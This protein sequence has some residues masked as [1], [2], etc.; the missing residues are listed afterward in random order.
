[1]LECH[2]TE[3]ELFMTACYNGEIALW[4]ARDGCILNSFNRCGGWKGRGS[5]GAAPR[6]V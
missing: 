1:M 2:P 4:S 5:E 3:P 6:R